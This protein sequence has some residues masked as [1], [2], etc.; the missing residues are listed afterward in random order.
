MTRSIKNVL[1]I[2]LNMTRRSSTNSFLSTTRR[3]METHSCFAHWRIMMS[4][5]LDMP[6]PITT[7]SRTT[8]PH[9][10][11]LAP[12]FLGIR[13]QFIIFPNILVINQR[14]SKT[15][16]AWR[17]LR[18]EMSRRTLCPRKQSRP[19]ENDDDSGGP[20]KQTKKRKQT[21]T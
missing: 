19:E 12:P 16:E 6:I 7:A 4:E 20:G 14:R 13:S 17:R 3:Q 15:R 2:K 21:T 8:V 1:T 11:H 10:C 9:Y 5:S 18:E